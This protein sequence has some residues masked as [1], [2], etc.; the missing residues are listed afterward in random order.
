MAPAPYPPPA[1]PPPGGYPPPPAQ[2]QPN[3]YPPPSGYAYPPPAGYQQSPPQQGY[4]PPAT[5]YYPPQQGGYPPA[6]YPPPPPPAQGLS[7]RR[8]FLALPFLGIN[9]YQG[10]TGKDMN[11]GLRLGVL[12][13]GHVNEQLSL[14]GELVIDVMNFDEMGGPQI[15]AADVVLALSPLFHLLI[16]KAELAVGPKV[17]LRSAAMS[18]D[19]SAGEEKQTLAGYV[20]GINAGFFTAVSNSMS[21]G[22]LLSAEIRTTHKLCSTAAGFRENC[23]TEDALTGAADKVIGLTAAALF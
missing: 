14:N 9:S 4:P 13:G 21:I 11:P 23:T 16:G 5:N 3:A 19:S 6:G 17:G 15:A 22:G 7:Q 20:I 2:Q 18:M 8:G 12:L 10:K 1:P